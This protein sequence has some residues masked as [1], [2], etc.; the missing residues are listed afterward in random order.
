MLEVQCRSDVASKKFR[1]KVKGK[2]SEV[3]ANADTAIKKGKEQAEFDAVVSVGA[4]LELE[5]LNGVAV[6][7]TA[8]K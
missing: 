8:K 3:T 6:T 4:K 2:E 5:V 1:I 7:I